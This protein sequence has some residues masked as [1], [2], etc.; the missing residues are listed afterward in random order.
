MLPV[1][2]TD[3]LQMARQWLMAGQADKAIDTVQAALQAAEAEG[4]LPRLAQAWLEVGWVHAWMEEFPEAEHAFGHAVSVL[5][6]Q[7]PATKALRVRCLRDHG[8]LLAQFDR[9]DEAGHLLRQAQA[10]ALSLADHGAQSALVAVPL[11][12]VL[13]A[14]EQVHEA[15]LLLEENLPA[16]NAGDQANLFRALTL[17]AETRAT[18][19]LPGLEPSHLTRQEWTAELGTALVEHANSLADT[20]DENNSPSTDPVVLRRLL[21]WLVDWLETTQGV[22][23][24]LLADTCGRLA[25]LESRLGDGPARVRAI[26]RAEQCYRARNEAGYAIQALQGK[27]LALAEM[28]DTAGAEVAYRAAL[29]EAEES[30][31]GF[32]ISQIERNLG[33]FRAELGDLPEAEHRLRRALKVATD[34]AHPELTGKAATALGMFLCHDSRGVEATSHLLM[35]IRVLEEGEPHRVAAEEHLAC[36][37]TGAVCACLNP[38]RQAC[39]MYRRL[40]RLALPGELVRDLQVTLVEGQME[41]RLDLVRELTAAEEEWVG[42]LQGATL[43]RLRATLPSRW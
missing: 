9:L 41:T 5:N 19:D 22:Q 32:L 3:R 11:A 37:K 15:R 13:L 33:Q 27:G 35:A 1:G 12:Q 21:R 31:S 40:L 4:H 42:E 8:L 38:E 30:A 29:A 24:R 26:V 39:E 16:L 2:E 18:L 28:G 36:L 23:S 7:D 25:N 10:D 20:S 17:L 14:S 6:P 34:N 43:E